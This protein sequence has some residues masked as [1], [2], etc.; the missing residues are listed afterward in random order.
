MTEETGKP[1][2]FSQLD[3]LEKEITTL[4]K[5]NPHALILS[6]HWTQL[7]S[8]RRQE[9]QKAGLERSRPPAP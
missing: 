1:K 7:N 3:Q 6:L 5:R 9:Q 8:L 4:E 2:T